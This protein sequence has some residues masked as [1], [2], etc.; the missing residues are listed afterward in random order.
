MVTHDPKTF[1]LL[2]PTAEDMAVRYTFELG[3]FVKDRLPLNM[4]N[5]EFA[6]ASAAML[7]ALSRRLGDCAAAYAQ[8]NL[9]D[10][11]QVGDTIVGMVAK[12]FVEGL[13]TIGMKIES[14]PN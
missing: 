13:M 4:P 1:V 8:A 12:H 14:E 10:P 5:D 2:P 11:P 7:I 6:L 3:Q 9:V